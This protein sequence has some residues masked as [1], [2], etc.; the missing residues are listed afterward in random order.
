MF[1]NFAKLLK[2]KKLQ[3]KNQD[4]VIANYVKRFTKKNAKSPIQTKNF[5]DLLL[6]Y[7]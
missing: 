6:V 1:E 4:K 5:E 7:C 3:I 2:D